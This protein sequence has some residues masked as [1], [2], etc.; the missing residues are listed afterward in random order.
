MLKLQ[1]SNIKEN[2]TMGRDIRESTSQYDDEHCNGIGLQ[3]QSDIGAGLRACHKAHKSHECDE[4]WHRPDV[5]ARFLPA[6]RPRDMTKCCTH[7]KLP[8]F[9]TKGNLDYFS[10]LTKFIVMLIF[11]LHL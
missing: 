3:R 7:P 5:G 6:I 10:F 8:R 2:E 11:Y 1:S 4:L 9:L